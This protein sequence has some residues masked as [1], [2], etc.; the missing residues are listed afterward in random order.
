MEM[1]DLC[2]D[3]VLGRVALRTVPAP[4][5]APAPVGGGGEG[6]PAV[7]TS[8]N[9]VSLCGENKLPLNFSWKNRETHWLRCSA[10]TKQEIVEGEDE[11]TVFLFSTGYGCYQKRSP[12]ENK[13]QKNKI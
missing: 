10:S 7:E 5:P 2:L 13:K 6:A 9:T 3:H 12:T 4:A 8:R 1:A 11:R